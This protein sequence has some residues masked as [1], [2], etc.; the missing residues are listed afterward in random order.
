MPAIQVR[1]MVCIRLQAG[2]LSRGERALMPRVEHRRHM[3][4]NNWGENL[5]Q[6]TR[7][8]GQQRKRYNSA[9]EV[10]RFSLARDRIN[11]PFHNRRNHV[12]AIEFF[13]TARAEALMLWTELSG[14]MTV[15]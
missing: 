11:N 2:D 7:R 10:Q 4:P 6:R 8:H 13:R 5:H 12:T 9:G 1:R 14:A 3:S 15:A